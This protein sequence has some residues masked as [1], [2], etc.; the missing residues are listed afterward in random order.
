[1]ATI[2]RHFVL[3]GMDTRLQTMRLLTKVQNAKTQKG[4]FFCRV[5]I[6]KFGENL[7]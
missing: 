2:H 6:L 4:I 3:F 7:V 5:K 1:M